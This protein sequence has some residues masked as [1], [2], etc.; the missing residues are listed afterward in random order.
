MTRLKKIGLF[1]LLALVIVV[2]AT[3]CYCHY[4]LHRSYKDFFTTR[5]APVVVQEPSPGQL[6]F[7]SR[8]GK[9]VKAK[10]RL[11]TKGKPPYPA[12]VLMGGIRT[13]HKAAGLIPDKYINQGIAVISLDYR[14]AGRL[15]LPGRDAKW[16]HYL[17]YPPHLIASVDDVIDAADYLASRKDIDK[18]NIFLIGVSF[19]IYFVPAAMAAQ[20]KYAALAIVYGGAPMGKMAAHNFKILPPWSRPMIGTL[21]DVLLAPL[22]PTIHLPHVGERP[23]LYLVSTEDEQI[24]IE[25][26]HAVRDSIKGPKTLMYLKTRHV[27]PKD[28]KLISELASK[29]MDWVDERIKDRH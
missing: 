4:R 17:R 20:E 24:P 9:P 22:E 2:L 18:N 3:W 28:T 23:V 27:N 1:A 10:L 26:V 29:A 5:N 11:P 15:P 14:V 7:I 8:D 13:G 25:C 12:A 16:H 19:G 21:V 6:L